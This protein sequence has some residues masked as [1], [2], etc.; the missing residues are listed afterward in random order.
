VEDLA[1]DWLESEGGNME[2]VPL[3]SHQE[4]LGSH[5]EDGLLE[6]VLYTKH[7]LDDYLLEDRARYHNVEDLRTVVD[8]QAI[9]LHLA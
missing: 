1:V 7:H 2:M 9:S 3:E 8:P 6:E 5:M 4:E